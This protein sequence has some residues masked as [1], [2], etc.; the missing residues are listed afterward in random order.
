ME[1]IENL[2]SQIQELRKMDEIRNLDNQL[3]PIELTGYIS[4]VR[5]CFNLLD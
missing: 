5:V 3:E 1:D 2:K 4:V